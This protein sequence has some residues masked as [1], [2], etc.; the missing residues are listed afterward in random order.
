MLMLVKK[1]K[2]KLRF[3]DPILL[4]ILMLCPL[5]SLTNTAI[6]SLIMG[7]LTIIVFLCSMI[8]IC[9]IQTNIPAQLYLFIRLMIIAS[10]TTIVAL[11]FQAF[12][13]EMY[14]Q[15]EIFIPS[16]MVNSFILSLCI[17]K[18]NGLNDSVLLSG[19]FLGCVFI[20]GIFR[21][22]LGMGQL[23]GKQIT[24]IYNL[25]SILSLAP[26]IFFLFA[27]GLGIINVLKTKIN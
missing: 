17:K 6:N 15:F 20:I 4:Q 1:A 16:I 3:D 27:I 10:F 14:K 11:I 12:N 13:F 8:I 25:T 26:G 5:I 24:T 18:S 22:I 7:G 9:K 19:L 23:F 2:E 21:E